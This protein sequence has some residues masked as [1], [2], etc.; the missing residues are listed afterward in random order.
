MRIS[1]RKILVG[2]TSV[3]AG[4]VAGTFGKKLLTTAFEKSPSKNH[5]LP[6]EIMS[7]HDAHFN[8]IMSSF[9]PLELEFVKDMYQ[10]TEKD[11]IEIKD[12]FFYS[13]FTF[14]HRIKDETHHSRRF[15]IGTYTFA[16]QVPQKIA[17][18][19]KERGIDLADHFDGSQLSG[20]GWDFD[21]GSFKVY[22]QVTQMS[23]LKSRIWQDLLQKVDLSQTENFGLAS[24]TYEGSKITESKIYV[25]LNKKGIE[26]A[27]QRYPFRSDIVHINQ[28]ICSRRGLVDQLD[29]RENNSVA[30]HLS[31]QGQKVIAKY[32]ELG[33]SLD[34]IA[35]ESPTQFTIYFG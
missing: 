33:L 4:V 8:S 12:D 21:E 14:S 18:I 20:L 35:F 1:R 26:Q 27:S 19:L 29:L 16:S 6:N 13:G 5:P 28:M 3:G 7:F 23:A 15:A 25:P 17:G 32:Q 24:I 22:S 11:G 30:K 9:T 10:L 2:L 31:S 34:T